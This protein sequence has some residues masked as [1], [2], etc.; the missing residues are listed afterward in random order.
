MNLV[1]GERIEICYGSS[2]QPPALLAYVLAPMIRYLAVGW[3]VPTAWQFDE[4]AS[5]L[6]IIDEGT[7]SDREKEAAFWV[8]PQKLV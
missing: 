5:L 1:F 2:F 4:G 7:Q 6:K 8:A 3:R